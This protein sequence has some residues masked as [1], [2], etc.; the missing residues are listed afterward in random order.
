MRIELVFERS[1][2]TTFEHIYEELPSDFPAPVMGRV[3]VQKH[4]LGQLPPLRLVI[5]MSDADEVAG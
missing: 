5:S 2:Q 1:D 4:V 3:H